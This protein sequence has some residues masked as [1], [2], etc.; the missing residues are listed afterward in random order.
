MPKT[1]T[2]TLYTD[3][4]SP[5]AYLAKDPGYALE[6]IPGVDSTSCLMC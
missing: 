4:K 1:K 5:Y 2:V 6:S 3:Y